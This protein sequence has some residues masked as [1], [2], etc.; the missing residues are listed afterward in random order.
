MIIQL[1]PDWA[2]NIH[3]MLVHFP[4]AILGIAIFFDF[5]S[6]FLPKPKKWWTEEATA[7]LYGVG[8]LAAVI[9]Y[10][11]GTLA[12]DS[13]AASAAAESVMS[14]HADWAWWTI[15]FYGIYAVARIAATWMAH[16]K[17]RLKFHLGFFLLSFAGL[18][19]LFQ[20]GDHGARMV[21]EYGVGVQAVEVENPVEHDHS[22]HGGGEDN[23]EE[24]EAESHTEGGSSSEATSFSIEDNG[25]WTWEIEDN[26]VTVLDENFN[27]LSGS[28]ETVNAE[29]VETGT[30]HAL[31][32]SGENLNGFF[33]GNRT[34]EKEQVNYNVDMSSFD[35][36]VLFVNH[37]Q[38]ESSYDFVSIASDGTVKQGRMK[39][40]KT[41]IFKEGSTDVSQPLFVR[42]V[43]NGEH[44]KGYINKEVVVHGHGD[45]QQPGTVGLKMEGSGTLLL[46]KMSLTQL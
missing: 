41:T 11:T 8:A 4:I 22:N 44:Y 34:Y 19:L 13:V 23:H 5:I 26:A 21:F 45:A 39:D 14:N 36:T 40:G 18:F 29:A 17:H 6:F 2:P 10:Y 46:Q 31:S 30:G 33:A 24:G 25:D 32:F 16:E 42:V 3:P 7:F 38:N 9:V 43:G 28:A 35:G 27:W 12:A 1:L 20:T 15:W 37:L